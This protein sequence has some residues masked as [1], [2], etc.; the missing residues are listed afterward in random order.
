MK[1]KWA[2]LLLLLCGASQVGAQDMPEHPIPYP[3]AE[4]PVPPKPDYAN[5]DHWAA[6]PT[7][8]D[9]ADLT[10]KGATKENQANAAVDVFFVHPTTYYKGDP[11]NADVTNQVLNDYTDDMPIKH[12]A[13]VFNA[14]GK[15]YAPRYRQAHIRSFPN[16]NQGGAQALALAYEDVK[17]AFEYYLAHYNQGR[18]IV[19]A[20]HSQGTVHSIRL[21]KEFFDGQPLASQLVAAYLVGF[22]FKAETYTHFK[23]CPDSTATGCYVAWGAYADGYVPDFYD[24]LCKGTVCV[25]PITWSTDT[26]YSDYKQARGLAGWKFKKLYRK[27]L[28]ARVYDGMLWIT[29]PRI[30]FSFL[31]KM[32]V[33]H[34]ADYNLFWMDVRENVALRSK[35]YLEAAEAGP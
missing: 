12:Q 20:A 11:W 13:S 27:S 22:P 4:S 8:A 19:I 28:R 33:Y 29:K 21:V 14:T 34:I 3:F 9:K 18:P 23:V 16:M 2:I 7:K 17:A 24:T 35:H 6:L 25:N 1:I 15:V 10:P 32:K 5:P 30:P 31:I 26:A